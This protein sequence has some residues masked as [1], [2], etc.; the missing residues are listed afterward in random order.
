MGTMEATH[1]IMLQVPMAPVVEMEMVIVPT[2]H[3]QQKLSN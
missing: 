3:L 1:Q 2:I